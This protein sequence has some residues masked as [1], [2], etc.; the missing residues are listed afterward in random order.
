MGLK[1]GG[2]AVA[3]LWGGAAFPYN[4]KW[5]G[6]RPTSMPSGILVHPAVCSQRTWAEN[7]GAVPL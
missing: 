4:T 3:F 1:L 7:W 2:E 6:L 5:P